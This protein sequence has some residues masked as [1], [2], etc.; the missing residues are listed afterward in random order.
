MGRVLGAV[1]HGGMKAGECSGDIA[2]H[3]HI[4][5]LSL[6]VPLE[7]HTEVEG[8]CFIDGCCIFYVDCLMEV[9]EVGLGG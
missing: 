2:R 6:V 7:G 8:T 4:D 5:I 1:W 3:G 9:V